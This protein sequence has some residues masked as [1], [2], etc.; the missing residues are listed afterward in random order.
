M[1]PTAIRPAARR[2]PSYRGPSASR[3]YDWVSTS[4][5][6]TPRFSPGVNI[7]AGLLDNR[8]VPEGLVSWSNWNGKGE[9]LL[10]ISAYPDGNGDK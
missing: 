5:Q 6:T 7:P 2:T 8:Y 1:I 3:V 10:L 9:D 4:A